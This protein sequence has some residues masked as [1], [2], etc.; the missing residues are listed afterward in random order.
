MSLS[1]ATMP[2]LPKTT[3]IDASEIK[4][5]AC[6]KRGVMHDNNV[7]FYRVKIAT[8]GVSLGN[9]RQMHAMEMMMGGNVAIARALSPTTTIANED[10]DPVEAWL[11]FECAQMGKTTIAQLL[12]GD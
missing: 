11:C 3:P 4:P 9:L 12:E 7:I 1:E 10:T 2:N 8:C 6:C 5:C